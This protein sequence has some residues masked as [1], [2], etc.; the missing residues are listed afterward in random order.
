MISKIMSPGLHGFQASQAQLKKQAAK[1]AASTTQKESG[2]NLDRE[3]V[4]LKKLQHHAAANAK[5][6][7]TASDTIGTLLDVTA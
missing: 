5:T 7:K 3:M 1:V 4:E 6:I 2:V